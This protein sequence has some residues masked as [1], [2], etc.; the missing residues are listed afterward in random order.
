M[1]ACVRFTDFSFSLIVKHWIMFYMTL[2]IAYFIEGGQKV[3]FHS[4]LYLPSPLLGKLWLPTPIHALHW[5]RDTALSP[6]TSQISNQSTQL[7]CTAVWNASII[8]LT[9]LKLIGQICWFSVP[10]ILQNKIPQHSVKSQMKKS[11]SNH[12]F[13]IASTNDQS[14]V[15]R[16]NS[17]KS[18]SVLCSLSSMSFT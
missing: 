4:L 18:W 16:H 2:H 5:W 6:I 15:S 17:S 8:C 9:C 11:N 14:E 7:N 13:N 10:G 1:T 3:F 12:T